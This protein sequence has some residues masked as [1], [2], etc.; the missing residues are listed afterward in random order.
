MPFRFTPSAPFE[1]DVHGLSHGRAYGHHGQQY[2]DE[3][4]SQSHG[5]LQVRVGQ[6]GSSLAVTWQVGN[7]SRETY[8]QV[9]S[10]YPGLTI[11]GR[12]VV[13]FRPSKV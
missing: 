3:N 5:I 9:R 10:Q 13:S 2:C 12:S 11:R 8:E 4:R 7:V 6:M 1:V